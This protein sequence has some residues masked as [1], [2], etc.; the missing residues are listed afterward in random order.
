M[1]NG[2]R[3]HV[4]DT[5]KKKSPTMG[6][7][8]VKDFYVDSVH[9]YPQSGR[10]EFEETK[11]PFQPGDIGRLFKRES[12]YGG[13][14]KQPLRRRFAI[15]I[16]ACMLCNVD[17]TDSVSMIRILQTTFLNGPALVYFMDVV[18][19]HASNVE[20]AIQML[21]EHFLGERAKRVND[22]VWLELSFEFV[23]SS[24]QIHGKDTTYE[25]VLNDFLN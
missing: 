23:K 11:G 24:R 4:H 12:Q 16:D 22:E 9:D 13:G 8:N 7:G 6:A 19:H 15:F 14:P 3:D 1:D 2:G 20:D 17:I 10:S 21:E 5:G 18:K 25:G